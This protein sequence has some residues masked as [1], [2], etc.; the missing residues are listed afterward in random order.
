MLVQIFRSSLSPIF[1]HYIIT[2]V[3]NNRLPL[4]KQRQKRKSGK[5]CFAKNF[6]TPWRHHAV[7]QNWKQWIMK[8]DV[9]TICH[10]MNTGM[11]RHETESRNTEFCGISHS[12]YTIKCA[13]YVMKMLALILSV[14]VRWIVGNFRVYATET[15][16]TS[17][18]GIRV[19]PSK[20]DLCYDFIHIG[21]YF[22][23]DE[24]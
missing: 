24:L 4:C 9:C 3:T 22:D 6:Q 2:N 8:N 15:T 14:L 21:D 16:C 1:V 7:P 5:T 18:K 10:E 11:W 17:R 20:G 12:T 23:L 19:S 13:M